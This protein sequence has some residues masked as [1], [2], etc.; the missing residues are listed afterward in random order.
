MSGAHDARSVMHVQAHVAFR[1]TLW[2]T[3]VQTHAYTNGSTIRPGMGDEGALGCHCRRNSIAGTRKGDEE[4]IAL[5]I[6]FVATTGTEGRAQEET[7]ILEHTGIAFTQVLEQA[8]GPLDVGEEQ[9]DG[10]CWEC[11]HAAPRDTAWTTQARHS[12][13]TGLDD[14]LHPIIPHRW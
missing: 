14:G 5:G 7:G 10:S 13:A 1:R 3:S 6:D 8:C 12:R 4:A 11:M 2:F 9:G